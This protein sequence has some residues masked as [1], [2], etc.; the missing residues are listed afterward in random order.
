M[1]KIEKLMKEKGCISVTFDNGRNLFVCPFV[2]LKEYL[3]IKDKPEVEKPKE[4]LVCMKCGSKKNLNTNKD[5]SFV[6]CDKCMWEKEEEWRAM[7]ENIIQD[8]DKR[9]EAEIFIEQLIFEKTIETQQELVDDIWNEA[10]RLASRG[11]HGKVISGN[12]V[13]SNLAEAIENIENDFI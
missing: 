3:G 8:K 13:K 12:K 4:E 6:E 2:Y 5:K 7:L 1:E 9:K 10:F 11:K